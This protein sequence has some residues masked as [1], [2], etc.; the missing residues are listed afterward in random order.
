MKASDF[1]LN[2][3]SKKR[4]DYRRNGTGY[5]VYGTY[6]NV[7]ICRCSTA[8]KARMVVDALEDKAAQEVR[9]DDE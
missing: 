3:I 9:Y 7:G 2:E 8:D 1:Q 4:F 6:G 5:Q